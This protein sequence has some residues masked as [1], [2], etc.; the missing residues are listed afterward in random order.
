M[1]KS[2]LEFLGLTVRRKAER[3]EYDID[4]GSL[5]DRL[6]KRALAKSGSAVTDITAM[7]STAVWACIRV[8]AWTLASLPLITYRRLDPRGKE[9]A[10]DLAIYRLLH[11][12]PNPIQTSFTFRS[13]AMVHLC[14][15]GN[16]YAEIEYDGAGNPVA[17]WQLPPWRVRPRLAKRDTLFYE[18][19]LDQG[20]LAKIPDWAM[21]HIRGLSTN[22]LV[23]LSPIQQAAEAIGLSLAAEE[24]GARY[25]GDGTNLGGVVQHPSELSDAAYKRL[26]ESIKEAYAG[27]GKSH[28]LMFLEEGMKFEKLGIPPDQSQFLETRKFQVAE[29]SRMFG[30]P[31]HKL[32]E[33]DKATFSNIEHQA[34]EFVVD[35]MR[36]WLVNWE[37]EIGRKLFDGPEVFA[38]FLVDGLLRGD[39]ASRYQAYMTGRNWG[40]LSANDVREL[41]NMNPLPGEEGDLYLVPM[42]MQPAEWL[43]GASELPPVPAPDGSPRLPEPASARSIELRSVTKTR[44]RVAQSYRRVFEE[45]GKRIVEREAQNIRRAAKKNLTERSVQTFKDWTE[46][47]Y[48]DFAKFIQHQMGPASYALA[49][50]IEPLVKEQ[51]KKDSTANLDKLVEEY[52]AA[53]TARY[54]KSSRGQLDELLAKDADPSDEIEERLGEWEQKRPGKIGMN[55]TVQLSNAVAL[56][57][58]SG[59]GV[60]SLVWRNTSGKSCPYCEELDGK[61]VGTGEDFVGNSAFAEGEK[62]MKI[63]RPAMQPPLH[64]YCQCQVDPE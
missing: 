28:R 23:G 9:R 50:A 7:Q 62:P 29:I 63:R 61:V 64:E 5:A 40:W 6:L 39:T 21:L 48:R 8:L 52:L 27:L 32:G 47:F 44:F 33:L 53:F 4:D 18:V 13:T 56:T 17:L 2:L 11:D 15:H 22:G 43:T 42:N 19:Q 20:P 31:L 49:E 25:F 60:T 37:Q 57:F 34:I 51:I 54:I 16:A 12:S 45:A 36:P 30:L 24:F 1:R 38:E 55:E 14:L 59:A 41:E 10:T 58:F 35:T 26:K 3:R 46:D